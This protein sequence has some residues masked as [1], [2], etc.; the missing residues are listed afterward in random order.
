MAYM[1]IIEV[2]KA[3]KK[4]NLLDTYASLEYKSNN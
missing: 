2:E 4:I 1:M 3:I